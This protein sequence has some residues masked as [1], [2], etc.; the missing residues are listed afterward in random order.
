MAVTYTWTINYLEK[1]SDGGITLAHYTCYGEEEGNSNVMQGNVSF[2]PDSSAADFIAFNDVTESNVLSWVYGS[3]SQTEIE[4]DV[5]KL[6]AG[7]TSPE[8]DVAL[9]WS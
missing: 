9:P 4:A 3:I 1:N 5:A 6:I 8:T 7:S 2:T